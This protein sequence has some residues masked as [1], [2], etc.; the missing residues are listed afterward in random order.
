MER[1]ESMIDACDDFCQELMG[2]SDTSFSRTYQG[3]PP[4]R[5]ICRGL[6]LTVMAD[7]SPLCRGH[8]LLV[9]NTHYFS[10]SEVAKNHLTELADTTTQVLTLYRDTFGEPVILEHGSVSDMRGSSCITHA[11]WHILPL[12]PGKLVNIMEADGLV[13]TELH[14]FDNLAAIAARKVP[15]FLV[16][17]PNFLRLFGIGQV[18]RQQYLRSIVGKE[19]GIPD[20]EWDWALVVRKHLL[21]NNILAAQSWELRFGPSATQLEDK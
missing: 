20:P 18:M 5:I 7:L 12:I 2:E 16:A 19:L 3:N 9:S 21:R 10:F 4:S 1:S 13:S 8:I 6:N 14:S 17:G 15:Y 11:H